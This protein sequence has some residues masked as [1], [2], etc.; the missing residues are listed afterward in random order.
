V[1]IKYEVIELTNRVMMSIGFVVHFE[2][3]SVKSKAVIAKSST[4]SESRK[5]ILA[6]LIGYALNV[7]LKKV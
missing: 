1:F 2:E 6:V 7:L 4:A 3:K 5:P